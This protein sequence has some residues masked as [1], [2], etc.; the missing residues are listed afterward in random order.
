[1]ST[2]LSETAF[3]SLLW[4]MGIR[5]ISPGW[6]FID[7]LKRLRKYSGIL[8][9]KSAK[10][11]FRLEIEKTDDPPESNNAPPNEYRAEKLAEVTAEYV[12][13]GLK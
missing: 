5:A 12:T 10:T 11:S 4:S 9:P 13:E 6:K 3:A 7:S 8:L 2:Q 1:M